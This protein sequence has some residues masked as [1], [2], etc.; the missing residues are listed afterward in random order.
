MGIDSAVATAD[1]EKSKGIKVIDARAGVIE[2]GSYV[3]FRCEQDT[4]TYDFEANAI[5]YAF[6]SKSVGKHFIVDLRKKGDISLK[7]I[8]ILVR[9]ANI[10]KSDIQRINRNRENERSLQIIAE[11]DSKVERI[12]ESK[13]IRNSVDLHNSIPQCMNHL[14]YERKRKS[15]VLE[16]YTLADGSTQYVEVERLLQS[17]GSYFPDR[18][19]PQ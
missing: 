11:K 7:E 3:Y 13:H 10:S 16:G 17:L 4:N 15:S 12:I 14:N 1:T 5:K 8:L 6:Y 9:A 19:V 2:N 18:T